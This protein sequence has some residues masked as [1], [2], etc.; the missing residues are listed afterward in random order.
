MKNAFVLLIDALRYDVVADPAALRFLAPNLHALSR[1]ALVRRVITNAQSTQFV[2]PSLFTCTYPLDHGGYNDGIRNRPKSFVELLREAGYETF[3]LA[4]ANQLGLSLGYQRGF[5]VV[6]TTSD[7]RTQVEYRISRTMSHDIERYKR[8]EIDERTAISRVRELMEPLLDGL[9]DAIAHHDRTIW[10]KG[11]KQ[12]NRRITES[13]IAE[14]KLLAVN[15]KAILAK[16][17]RIA[18]G[19]YWRYLG[20]EKVGGTAFFLQRALTGI[21][22]RTREWIAAQTFFPFLFLQHYQ[23]IAGDVIPATTRFINAKRTK[24]WFVHMHLMDLHDCRAANRIGHVFGLLRYFPRWLIARLRGLTRRRFLYDAALMYVDSQ[25]TNLLQKLKPQIAAGKTILFVTGDHGSQYA[26]SPRPKPSIGERM[27][28]EHIEVGLILAGAGPVHDE[29]MIDSMGVTASLLE[30]LGIAPHPSF[31][32]R[33]IG[34]G[35][36][37]VIV[38]ESCGAGY[39]D[40][41]NGDLYFAVTSNTHRLFLHQIGSTLSATRLYDHRSDPQELRNI[42]A[43]PD[44]RPV[45]ASLTAALFRE[46]GELLRKRN[47]DGPAAITLVPAT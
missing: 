27:F 38:S 46:R 42:I 40:V 47:V 12:L 2:M 31:K 20:Q 35:G 29:G 23:A 22:W 30:A 41:E 26:R 18:P 10:P 45:I 24:P 17:I 16:L 44:A 5:D 1:T 37:D 28:S 19:L 34:K 43:T 25:L 9:I 14:K 39:A 6:G 13:C 4:T 3:L 11:L 8:G 33:G 15:P 21:N 32:G 7:Y 36:R